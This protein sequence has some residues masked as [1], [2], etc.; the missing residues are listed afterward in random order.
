MIYFLLRKVNSKRTTHNNRFNKCAYQMALK[1]FSIY[2]NSEKLPRSFVTL[3]GSFLVQ[4]SYIAPMDIV[5]PMNVECHLR[6]NETTELKLPFILSQS[7][8]STPKF[9]SDR[10]E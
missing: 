1:G 10:Y 7:A 2:Q 3:S 8:K 6:P 4:V 5:F 9:L